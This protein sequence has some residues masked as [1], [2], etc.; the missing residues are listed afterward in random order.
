MTEL[1][2]F[3]PVFKTTNPKMEYSHYRNG[4][5]PGFVVSMV[6]GMSEPHICSR[7]PSFCP[8]SCQPAFH[9]F[10]DLLHQHFLENRFE[11]RQSNKFLTASLANTQL[12]VC[13]FTN[14]SQVG[15]IGSS[16]LLLLTLLMV[17]IFFVPPRIYNIQI[18]IGHAKVVN[19]SQTSQHLNRQF[20]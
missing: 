14:K 4:A 9:I 6:S 7:N 8:S 17:L 19:L 10:L 15:T 20:F 18:D 16:V 5:T 12:Q 3:L 13:K 1:Y 11:I 2:H